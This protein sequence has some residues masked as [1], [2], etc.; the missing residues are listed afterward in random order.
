VRK[1]LERPAGK[2]KKVGVVRVENPQKRK[3][4]GG[5]VK[6]VNNLWKTC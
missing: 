5:G 2:K 3:K 6:S 1:G 4:K